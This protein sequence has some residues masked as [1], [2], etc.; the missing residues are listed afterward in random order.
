L[1]AIS[2]ILIENWNDMIDDPPTAQPNEPLPEAPSVATP[3]LAPANVAET[4]DV[5]TPAVGPSLPPNHAGGTSARSLSRWASLR[6]SRSADA[7]QDEEELTVDDDAEGF[8]RSAVPIQKESVRNT[9][10]TMALRAAITPVVRARLRARS[11]LA[12][13]LTVPS[14]GWLGPVERYFA[15]SA[16]G[17]KWDCY[18]R[19]GS[20]RLQDKPSV[21]NGEVAKSLANGHSVVGIAINPMQV[22]PATLLS[23]TDIRISVKLDATVVRRAIRKIYGKTSPPI[24]ESDLAG[25]DIHDVEAAMR[26]GTSVGEVATRIAV[27]SKIRG[28]SIAA[29]EVPDLETAVEYGAARTW[30]LALADDMRA[31]RDGRLPWSALDRGAIFYSKP[32]MGK[33]LLARSLALK[34]EANLVVGS[35]GEIFATSNGHL[36]GVIKAMRELFAKAIAAAPAILFLDECD[37][38]PSRGSLESRNRDF[39]MPVIEDF[40]LLLDDATSGKREGV[41]VIGATNRIEAVDP[42]I[43]RPGRLER[44]I[45]ITMPNADGVLNVLRFHVRGGLSDDELRTV[46]GLLEGLTPAEIMETVRAARRLARQAGRPIA[47]VDIKK[48]ALPDLDLPPEFIQRIA[49]HEAGHVVG[50]VSCGGRVTAVRI[51]GR[52]GVGGLTNMELGPTGLATRAS[53][54]RRV[55]VLLA[56]RAAEIALL[57]SASSGAGGD[58]LSDLAESSRLLAAM[59]LSYGLADDELLYRADSDDALR[60]LSRDPAARRR[61]DDMLKELQDRALEIA[62]D[63]RSQIADI[64]DALFLRRFLQ[65]KD[66]AA[67]LARPKVRPIRDQKLDRPR[68]P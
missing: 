13:T 47:A 31:F 28:T 27:A 46:V 16:F 41:V 30:G 21:G 34:C 35:I 61:V 25:L 12:L 15:S 49:V 8:V 9:I 10:V 57:G 51:G 32:G 60:E 23:A 44:A 45:E 58:E 40:L 14:A 2:K 54:E 53:I 67:I 36:D 63:H 56:G 1:S 50:A 68:R 5:S 29:D 65:E 43:L 20:S 62:R 55:I 52:K 42:A 3:A 6:N 4:N 17:R 66:I 37:G 39:W 33:S 48:A 38:L 19:D 22:L 11:P 59:A 7:E 18:S 64:A 26:P 24:A